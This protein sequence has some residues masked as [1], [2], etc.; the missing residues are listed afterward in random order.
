[1]VLQKL[2]SRIRT[3]IEN[4]V[5]LRQRSMFVIVGDQGRDKV[6]ILHHML[7]KA[8]VKSRPSV[9]WCY[10]KEL[11]FSSH[12]KKRMRQLQKKLKSGN[13]AINK[14][15]P[16][17]LFIASTNIRYCY[18]SETFKILGNTFGMLILQ[19]FEALTPNI[20]ARTVETVE[21]G[22]LVIF[23]LKSMNSLKKLFTFTM[24]VHSRYRTESHQQ[25]ICRFNE[26]F[27][28]SLASCKQCLVMDD[29]F[30]ILP[31]SSSSSNITPIAASMKDSEDPKEEELKVLK[32]SL[33]DTQPVCSLLNLTKTLDQAKALL[34]FIEVISEKTLTSTI[35]LTAARG[36][37]KSAALGLVIAGA[38]AFR[39]ARLI[40][41]YK[42]IYSNIFVT[43]PSPENL[44]TLFEFVFKGFD[45]LGYEE[46]QDYEIIQST[47]PEYN[48]AV[49]RVNVFME[50][51]QTIQYFHP[52]D[53]GKL[54]QAE[55]VVIDEAAAIPLPLVR[56]IL[57][58]YLVFMASTINGYEGTGR[59][60][61]L[62]LIEQLRQQQATSAASSASSTQTIKG[63]AP[64]FGRILHEIEL[65]ESIRYSNG[66]EIEKWLYKLLCLDISNI[67]RFITACPSPNDCELYPNNIQDNTL[68]SCHKASEAFLQRLMSIYVASHYK[69][70]PND[71]QMLSDAPAHHLFCLLGPSIEKSKTLPDI[72]CV[73]QV[74]LE[75]GISKHLVMNSL[76]QGKR[77][78]GD[79][80]PWTISQQFQDYNFGSLSG[81]R[82]IRIA[83][84]PD[85]QGLGYGARALHLLQE[86]YEGRFSDLLQD[87]E[88]NETTATDHQFKNVDDDGVS[89]LD[90]VIKPR[91][92]LPPLLS[93]LTE[94][95]A[96][97]LD[98]LG[99]SYG[100]TN[101]LLRFWTKSGY[102]PVYIRQTPN[103]LT[104]EHSCIMLKVLYQDVENNPNM[105]WLK[106]YWEDFRKRFLTLLSYQFRN[107]LPGL[108]LSVLS[109]REQLQ[110]SYKAITPAELS[111]I[112]IKYDLKR[113]DIYSR[114]MADYHL[115]TDLLPSIA[116]LYFTDR[117]EFNLSSVQAAILL[118]LGLQ[119]KTIDELEKELSLPST[120][121]LGLFNRTIRKIVNHFNE[122]EVADLSKQI[123]EDDSFVADMKPVIKTLKEELTE[124]AVDYET[125]KNDNIKQ[126]ENIN[127]S[128]YSIAG[129]ESEWQDALPKEKPI[130]L[131]SIKRCVI[132]INI[133]Y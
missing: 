99:V 120:Q 6:V 24:D 33:A 116:K 56:S 52:S 101:Q 71:L 125:K 23:L 104:G 91:S 70:T 106:A 60:L 67:Q 8:T 47:N 76:S 87:E 15:D 130:G 78:S 11:G 85:L 122:I 80:I 126:L 10:K 82:V 124:A 7:T 73:I 51:R 44:H 133:I 17:E 48:K 31:I 49:I 132:Q 20:L 68:F 26:R 77:A 39:H 64:Y 81:A 28:L 16:F 65:N 92:G 97:K 118:G 105:R 72:L 69:N 42:R 37:G 131:V 107:F 88:F 57:G 93:N 29:Q 98:Y 114:K 59:S 62:K 38:I 113:L 1:M 119:R 58:P 54:G 86:F 4:G 103:D 46:H 40:F 50:H 84:H 22:G 21:G 110:S 128:E 129:K 41:R 95:K 5:G 89:L 30:N 100:L 27:M 34:R 43:S 79:M 3:L 115:V 83:T 12:R 25:V 18:Y 111:S 109:K 75:G 63:K 66:D 108:G 32:D 121:L 53:A 9:L 19:D 74:C 123:N 45:A 112:F 14:D 13:V 61:S 94:C 117:F 35:A 102:V 96:P 90:E 2:D 127:L 55:L 36:R